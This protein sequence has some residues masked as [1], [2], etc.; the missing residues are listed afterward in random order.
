MTFQNFSNNDE[1]AFI[2]LRKFLLVI[3]DAN[4]HEQALNAY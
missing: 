3:Q 2:I 4:M 1:G